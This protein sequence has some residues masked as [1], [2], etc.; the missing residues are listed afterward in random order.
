MDDYLQLFKDKHPHSTEALIRKYGEN[1]KRRVN[2][3][4]EALRMLC[5][6]EATGWLQLK[7]GIY[8]KKVR[9]L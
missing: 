8:K 7:L 3:L 5:H 6:Q 9:A 4:V 1:P 2:I